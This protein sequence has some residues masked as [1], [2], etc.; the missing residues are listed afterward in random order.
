VTAAGDILTASSDGRVQL[1]Q[2][3]RRGGGGGGGGGAAQ[4]GQ[5]DGDRAARPDR[6]SL[7]RS[8]SQGVG[9]GSGVAAAAGAAGGE[10]SPQPDQGCSIM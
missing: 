8:N 4:R 6:S 1:F 9:G 7:I 5:A 10:H 2:F 3:E